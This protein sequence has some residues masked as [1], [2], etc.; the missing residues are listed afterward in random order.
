[1]KGITEI[2][3]PLLHSITNKQTNGHATPY[4]Q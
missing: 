2:F 1:M 4:I 3:T